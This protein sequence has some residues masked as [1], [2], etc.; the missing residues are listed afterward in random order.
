MILS[1]ARI[2]GEDKGVIHIAQLVLYSLVLM[3]VNIY[4]FR[5]C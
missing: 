3:S 4:D 5:S 1:L 2:K